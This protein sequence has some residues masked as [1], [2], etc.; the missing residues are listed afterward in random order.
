MLARVY[1]NSIQ[2]LA[3]GRPVRISMYG[4]ECNALAEHGWDEHG[5]PAVQVSCDYTGPDG[6]NVKGVFVMSPTKFESILV[7]AQ[8][9]TPRLEAVQSRIMR[10]LTQGG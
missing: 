2:D 3:A 4:R 1:Q 8:S 10:R 9:L 5:N 7:K 6:E